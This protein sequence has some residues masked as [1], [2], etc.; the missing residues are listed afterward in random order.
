MGSEAAGAEERMLTTFVFRK[1]AEDRKNTSILDAYWERV[2]AKSAADQAQ[3]RSS[4]ETPLGSPSVSFLPPRS[5]RGHN[6][7]RSAS[8]GTALLPPGHKLSPYHPAWSLTTLLDTFGPLIF[9]IH[10]AA[11]LRKR[12]LISCHAPVHEV[13]NFGKYIRRGRVRMA[14]LTMIR[15]SLRHL[16][17]FQH[18]PF[19]HGPPLASRVDRASPPALHHRRARHPVPGR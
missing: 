16:D 18:S 13:C 1:L 3:D 19:R 8:D 12:I 15:R 14:V 5:K 17:P 9:P 11:L 4:V 2:R 10:R 7:N 6:R